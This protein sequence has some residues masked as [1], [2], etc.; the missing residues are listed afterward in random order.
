MAES[1]AIVPERFRKVL[2]GY[3]T[4]VCV[5]TSADAESRY[6]MVVGTFTSISLDP[7][8]VGFFPDKSST[9]WPKIERTGRFCVNVLSAGQLDE[10]KHFA[11]KLEDKFEG[12]SHASSP[13]NLPLLDAA[14]AWIECDISQVNEI[15]DHLLVVGAVTAMDR[16]VDGEPLLFFG[17]S[18]H[19]LQPLVSP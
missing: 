11:S 10:C 1:P 12:R 18:Y 6:G 13:G 7:P 5:I 15:G 8:L 4:G 19:G 9:S 17:G 3:P 14:I 2:G 16:L